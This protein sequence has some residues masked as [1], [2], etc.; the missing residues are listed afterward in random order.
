MTPGTDMDGGY[1]FPPLNG[2]AWEA[3]KELDVNQ[4]MRWGMITSE[5]PEGVPPEEAALTPWFVTK[6]DTSGANVLV[7]VAPATVNPGNVM[8]TIG[9]TAL[10]AGT[11][12]QLSVSTS[13][14]Q[15]V[16]ATFNLSLSFDGNGVLSGFTVSSVT[17][18]SGSSLTPD[19]YGAGTYRRK[20][21]TFVD[22]EKTA[23]V[24]NYSLDVE[25][26]NKGEFA[27]E[28]RMVAMASG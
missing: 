26:L 11:P 12:P 22:G 1:P 25:A 23:Q 18:S 14:T 10:D 3:G 7:T 16:I 27:S 21:A 9:G 28:A 17:I 19:D 13:G 2:R 15:Y 8:P 6:V 20:I 24:M 4:D 5:G